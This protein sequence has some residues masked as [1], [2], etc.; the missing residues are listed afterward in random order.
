[1]VIERRALVGLAGGQRM[2]RIQRGREILAQYAP[3]FEAVEKAYATVAGDFYALRDVNIE[4]D[5]G[6]FVSIVG[7][8]GSGK[9]TLLNMIA[10]ID[11]PTA[12]RI[13]VDEVQ[14]HALGEGRLARWRG[15]TLGIV[16]QF[17]QL[18][19]TLTALENVMLP[20]DFAGFDRPSLRPARALGLLE[21]VDMGAHADKLP[22][23]LSGGEQ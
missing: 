19:P 13:T 2:T 14:V 11:H 16:F 21:L 1:M 7:K 5:H 10:G 9:S 17:F 6:E 18:M 22:S 23:A 8:S 4:I 20:M 12:G 3:T 15:K